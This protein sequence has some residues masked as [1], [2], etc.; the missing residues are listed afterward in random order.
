MKI[1][2]TTNLWIFFTALTLTSCSKKSTSQV[3][4]QAKDS[5]ASSD[6]KA[7]LNVEESVY[8]DLNAKSLNDLKKEYEQRRI[9]NITDTQE[10]ETLSLINQKLCTARQTL[11]QNCVSTAS[12]IPNASD[13]IESCTN[14]EKKSLGLAPIPA[15]TKTDSSTTA[16]TSGAPKENEAASAQGTEAGQ[17]I[18]A[19][20]KM[21]GTYKII[22]ND[23]FESTAFGA[24]EHPITFRTIGASDNTSPQFMDAY[25]IIIKST[26]GSDMPD[27]GLFTGFELRVGKNPLAKDIQASSDSVLAK[28]QYDIS[29][30]KILENRNSD[31]CVFKDSDVDQIKAQATSTIKQQF[32]KKPLETLPANIAKD[33]LIGKISTLMNDISNRSPEL[34]RKRNTLFKLT[35]ELKSKDVIGCHYNQKITSF[36][37][38]IEG[39]RKAAV[40]LGNFSSRLPDPADSGKSSVLQFKFGAVSIAIDQDKENIFGQH[41]AFKQ[42]LSNFTIGSLQ[43]IEISKQGVSYDQRQVNDPSGFLDKVHDFFTK[44][45]EEYEVD[46]LNVFNISGVKLFVNGK[47]VYTKS[48][49]NEVLRKD[50]LKW[51]DQ[52]LKIGPDW[53]KLMTETDC[54]KTK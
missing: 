8:K 32:A 43:Y 23:A 44:A 20:P 41:Y 13:I 54:E 7:P 4:S 1:F 25:K 38:E 27:K 39:E 50:K 51:M 22:I 53:I 45:G 46:E 36:E 2:K 28:K 16:Q 21:G 15:D 42:D 29:V 37:I 9:Q 26:D 24:G 17:I 40:S 33:S 18:A 10:L 34:E 6:N 5:S 31:Q 35:S 52:N 19:L 49:L 11:K 30:A 14:D 48:G 3:G 47:P 12:I